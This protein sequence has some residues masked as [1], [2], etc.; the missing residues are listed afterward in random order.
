M[1]RQVRMF[2]L[3]I[4]GLFALSSA[5]WAQELKVGFVN[6]PKFA[7]KSTRSMEQQK[8]LISLVEQ[9]RTKLENMKKELLALKDQIEK[10]GPMLKEET[11][12]SKIKEFSIKE[13]E[14]KLAEQEA[15]AEVQ[16]QERELQELLQKDLMKIVGKLRTDKGLLM[17]VNSQA[18]LSADDSLDITDEVIHLYDAAGGTEKPAATKPPAPRA[19]T[20]AAPAKK[21]NTK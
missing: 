12:S 11:R 15:Q 2:S 3:V 20:S 18:L 16:G 9:K 13:T 5:C 19:P 8:K 1:K 6:L 10:Q 7:S 14:L 4:A 21:P 17:V